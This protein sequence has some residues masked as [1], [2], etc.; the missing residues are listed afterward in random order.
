MEIL[1]F[2][3]P[4]QIFYLGKKGLKLCVYTLVAIFILI[5]TFIVILYFLTWHTFECVSLLTLCYNQNPNLFKK[6]MTNKCSKLKKQ[7][8]AYKNQS[9]SC[10]FWWCYELNSDVLQ[11]FIS[12]IHSFTAKHLVLR[13]KIYYICIL[14]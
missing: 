2:L 5:A 13:L 7:W 10:N 9:C 14:L 8:K 12:E 1:F 6:E 4:P 11:Q 3:L